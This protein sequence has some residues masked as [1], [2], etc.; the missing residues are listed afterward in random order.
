[1]V[2]PVPGWR[3]TRDTQYRLFVQPGE[4][5]LIPPGPATSGPVLDDVVFSYNH[6]VLAVKPWS[7]DRVF[8]LNS[9]V[10]LAD[11]LAAELSLR[12]HSSDEHQAACE[13][14]V[15]IKRRLKAG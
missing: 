8:H 12:Q 13:M 6:Y 15:R 2:L 9:A 11:T 5:R 1:M 3:D 14:L 10:C 7:Q 4:G